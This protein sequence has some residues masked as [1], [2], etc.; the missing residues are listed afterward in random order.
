VDN[1][2]VED[3]MKYVTHPK[4]VAI[5]ETGI[6]LYWRNDNLDKQ[7]AYF[8]KQLE[9]AVKLDKP[10]IIHTRNSFKEAFECV[11][12]FIGKVRGVFHSFSSNIEDAKLAIE[13]GFYIGITGVVTFKKAEALHEI[14]TNIPLEHIV[15][16]TDGPF[17]APVPFRG[18]RNVPAYN[19]Y[20]VEKIAELKG[21]SSEEV[22]A[23]TTDNAIKLFGLETL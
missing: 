10:I 15:V 8:I 13:A 20:V 3:I 22:A 2:E 9:L 4:V 6:D 5:G 21:I 18:K 1:L 23:K 17:L 7:K 16:E 14:V 11:K 12:P 19:K